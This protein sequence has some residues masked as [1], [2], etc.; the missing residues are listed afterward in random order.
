MVNYKSISILVAEDNAINQL[1][2]KTILQKEG[3]EVDIADNGKLAVEAL[4]K[5]DYHIVLMDLMMPEM[6]GYE[7]SIAIRN[8]SNPIKS[9][10]PIIAV[11]ADV[12][13]DVKDKCLEAGM[14]DYVSKPYDAHHLIEKIIEHVK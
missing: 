2:I 4:E 5:A 13:K 14:N 1:L 10:I 8:L 7:A 3:F 11:S 9:A 6:N 12:T